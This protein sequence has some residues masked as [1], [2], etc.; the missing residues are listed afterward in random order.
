MN[1]KTLLLFKN[2]PTSKHNK[3]SLRSFRLI[4]S[5]TNETAAMLA[6]LLDIKDIYVDEKLKLL[7]ASASPEKIALANRLIAI[8]RHSDPMVLLNWKYWK[9]PAPIKKQPAFNIQ[10]IFN[11]NVAGNSGDGITLERLRSLGKKQFI[12]SPVQVRN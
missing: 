6:G 9:F 8:K 12:L 2:T 1:E 11:I 5:D 7:V 4:H 10:R 3:L